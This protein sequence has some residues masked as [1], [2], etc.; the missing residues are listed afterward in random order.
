MVNDGKE[1]DHTIL[2]SLWH[3]ARLV[4]KSLGFS[5]KVQRCLQQGRLSPTDMIL[6][7]GEFMECWVPRID[8]NYP[9]SVCVLCWVPDVGY[10]SSHD[11]YDF[12]KPAST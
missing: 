12:A 4:V 5:L 6:E 8:K 2:I 10:P 11:L 3:S 7:Y 9:T 1:T